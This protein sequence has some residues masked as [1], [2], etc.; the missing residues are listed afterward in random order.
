MF[1]LKN[2]VA[3]I[4]GSTRG[5]GKA[6]ARSYAEAGARVVI[7]SRNADACKSVAGEFTE[8]GL[9]AVDIPCHVGRKDQLQTLVDETRRALGPIDI[10]VCNA[11][12]N[13]VYGP[14][15]QVPDDAFDTVINTNVRSVFQLCN[16]AVSY[17]HLTLPTILLV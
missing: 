2:K 15:H 3:I 7:S 13:P 12:T 10:L 4:T 14:M 9:Q 6:V 16:M 8:A 11:A 5:I 1:D 17:T